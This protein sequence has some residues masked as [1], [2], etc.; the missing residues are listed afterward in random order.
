MS[1][2]TLN[3]CANHPTVETNLRCN[4]CGK[5]ICA[6]CAVR[7]P[8]GYRCRECVR[9]QQ[10]TFETAQAT[11]YVL[12]FVVA[13]V[14]SAIGAFIAARIGFFTILLAPFAGGLIAEAVRTVTGRRRSPLL[15]R[16]AA[17]GVVMG[18][19]VFMLQPLVFLIST[20]DIRIFFNLL[21]PLLYVLLVT[22]AFYYRLSGIEIGR[23]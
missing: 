18:G 2:T 16:L 20:G 9:G 7:T 6:K 17:A 13:A 12:A 19:T 3:Y 8:T 10:K 22:S 21:W 5:F 14:L 15:F 23:R 11:D 1:E 4:N